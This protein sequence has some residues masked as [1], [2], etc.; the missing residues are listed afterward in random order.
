M[1]DIWGQFPDAQAGDPFAQFPDAQPAAPPPMMDSIKTIPGALVKGGA[2]LLTLPVT[3]NRLAESAAKGLV[4]QVDKAGRWA[5]GYPQL[6][7]EEYAS[8]D[9]EIQQMRGQSTLGQI[10]QA[11]ENAPKQAQNALLGTIEENRYQPQTRAGR[12]TDS[13]AQAVPG[14]MI[15]PGGVVPKL[16]GNAILPGAAMQVAR[17]VAPDN[18]YAPIVAGLLAQVAGTRAFTN[19]VAPEAVMTRAAGPI[20]DDQLNAARELMARAQE[21]GVHLTMPEAVHEA[22]GGATKLPELMRTVEGSA[23]GGVILNNVLSN[24]PQQ[25][26]GA[27]NSALDDIAPAGIS[28]SSLGPRMSGVADDIMNTARQDI[29]TQTRPLYQAAEPQALPDDVFQSFAADPAYQAGLARL[30]ADPVLGA[31]YADMPDN[32]VAVVDAVSKDLLASGTARAN[33]ANPLYGPERGSLEAGAGLTARQAARDSVGPYDQALQAQTQLRN[34]QLLPLEAGPVGRVA[35]AGDTSAAGQALMNGPVTADSAGEV[36][37]AVRRMA[38]VDPD[39]TAALL[40]QYLAQNFEDTLGKAAAPSIGWR[41]VDR[42]GPV[43]GGVRSDLR[44]SLIS[45]LDALPAQQGKNIDDLFGIL[46]ATRH[47]LP[48]GSPTAEKG[49]WIADLG[50]R[51]GGNVVAQ[52]ATKG[53]ARFTPLAQD[54]YRRMLLGQ[55]VTALA[56]SFVAPDAIDT[57]ARALAKGSR[58]PYSEAFLRSAY[59][60]LNSPEGQQR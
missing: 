20:T 6:T 55:N 19:Q 31:R 47:R 57:L 14:G 46:E 45:G 26:A 59:N 33:S 16:I 50:T 29:N 49:Q 43:K 3:V 37:D 2:E 30:R 48:P 38:E 51:A 41:F 35:R 15:G 23:Q 28:P 58:A 25:I 12:I 34:Q 53:L 22:T 40:R 54:A 4:N 21:R 56:D 1:A 7:P 17:E 10:G 11:I 18:P 5:L 32:S 39:G 44:E 13:I 8:R 36:A 24:R 27:V 60:T 52:M 9:A 42:V